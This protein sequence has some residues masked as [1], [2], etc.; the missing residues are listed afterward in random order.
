MFVSTQKTIATLASLATACFMLAGQAQAA[1]QY[2]Y[3]HTEDNVKVCANAGV[4]SDEVFLSTHGQY[5]ALNIKCEVAPGELITDWEVTEEFGPSLS[6][7]EIT[8]FSF[9]YCEGRMGV[10]TID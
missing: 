2:D 1:T 8:D 5:L 7:D 4:T 10:E 9:S 3:C 6:D